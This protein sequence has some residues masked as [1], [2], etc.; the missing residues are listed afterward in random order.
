VALSIYAGLGT[1][2]SHRVYS[3]PCTTT[4]GVVGRAC[5]AQRCHPSLAVCKRVFFCRGVKDSSWPASPWT[6][7]HW[8]MH[9]NSSTSG[10]WERF[11]F[12]KMDD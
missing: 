10:R 9:V 7:P 11:F 8:T 12:T 3:V 2:I 5:V 1:S 4:F 6:G